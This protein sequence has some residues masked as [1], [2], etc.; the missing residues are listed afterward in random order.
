[1]S[2]IF[3]WSSTRAPSVLVT[4]GS[5]LTRIS[6]LNTSSEE[7]FTIVV[8]FTAATVSST[9][10]AAL[11]RLSNR[12][13]FRLWAGVQPSLSVEA[14]METPRSLPRAEVGDPDD[15]A[16]L[17]SGEHPAKPAPKDER[18]QMT[19]DSLQNYELLKPIPVVI[20]SL[21]DKFFTAEVP[22][23]N[24]SISETSLAGALLILKDHITTIYEEYRMK[25]MLNPEQARQLEILQI[26]I[27][28][29][30]RLGFV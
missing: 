12:S 17:A 4:C 22:E 30:R 2:P 9:Q 8:P 1:M 6:V 13:R 21:S 15:L 26:Y 29:T 16:K 28:K 7:S 14:M 18:L 11:R 10:I 25:K 27:G 19:I 24:L 23:L 20:E 3:F 5:Y